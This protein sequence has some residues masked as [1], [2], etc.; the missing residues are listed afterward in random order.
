MVYVSKSSVPDKI[1]QAKGKITLKVF[2]IITLLRVVRKNATF[3]EISFMFVSLQDKWVCFHL[4]IRV[5]IITRVTRVMIE[6]IRSVH[7]QNF[8]K[9]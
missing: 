9:G 8:P 4:I 7:K 6:I 3:S 5:I 2:I 1:S